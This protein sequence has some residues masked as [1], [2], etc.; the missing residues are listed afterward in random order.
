MVLARL[1]EK[2]KEPWTQQDA[3]EL[4][5]G[6]LGC[7]ARGGLAFERFLGHLWLRLVGFRQAR[8]YPKRICITDYV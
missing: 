8:D 4:G 5:L 1:V 2:V 3:R 6:D 7:V